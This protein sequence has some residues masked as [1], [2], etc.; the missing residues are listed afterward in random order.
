MTMTTSTGVKK[1]LSKSAQ[2]VL[3]NQKQPPAPTLFFGNLSFDTTEDSI[4]ELLEAHHDDKE[5]HRRRRSNKEEEEEE[6][7]NN[8]GSDLLHESAWIR[9]VRLSTFE[10]S[11]KCKGYVYIVFWWWWW[12]CFFSCSQKYKIK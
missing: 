12:W 4:R 6:N 11:G 3:K 8:K 10:D 5:K 7:N 9:K 2:K 1:S